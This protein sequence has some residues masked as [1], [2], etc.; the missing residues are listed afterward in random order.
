MLH[1][2]LELSIFKYLKSSD[3]CTLTT[4]L[5]VSRVFWRRKSVKIYHIWVRDG[6]HVHVIITIQ[7]NRRFLNHRLFIILHILAQSLYL[8][9]MYVAVVI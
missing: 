2:G 4:L 3:L 6:Y 9:L 5:S 7:A 1:I 8:A